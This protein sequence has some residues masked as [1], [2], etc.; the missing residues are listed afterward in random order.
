MAFGFNLIRVQ[1]N[2]ISG[3]DENGYPTF[4]GSFTDATVPGCTNCGLGLAD[5]LLGRMSDFQQTNATPDDLRQWVMSIY[6]QD[7]FKVS[8]R[9]HAELRPALGADLRRSRQVR[10]RNVI[11]SMR[12]S[13]RVST[14]RCIPM[15]LPGC[16]FPATREFPPPTGTGIRPISRRALGLVWNPSR[17]RPATPCAWAAAILY[18]VTETWFNERETTNPPI[19]TI[20]DVATGRR[21]SDESLARLPRRKSVSPRTGNP[22]FPKRWHVRQHADQPRAHLRGSVER[23]LP[24]ADSPHLGGFGKLPGQRDH[25]PLDR[26]GEE[27]RRCIFRGTGAGTIRPHQ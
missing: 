26:G 1:N 22:L 21:T 19:G 13:W 27:T 11:Q 14:A 2:T 23:Y 3:F 18:D 5:F 15:R 20:V 17:R 16:S 24:A 6:A 7:S 9:L 25:A 10:P 12:L 4:N 8:S